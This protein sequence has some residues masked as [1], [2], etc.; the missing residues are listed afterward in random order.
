LTK[1][2]QRREK[3]FNFTQLHKRAKFH[4]IAQLACSSHGVAIMRGAISLLLQQLQKGFI[5]R[6]EK[7]TG[8]VLKFYEGFRSRSRNFEAQMNTFSVR[9]G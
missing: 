9:S 3:I 4:P 5:R 2:I 6:P 8:I 7:R 1:K